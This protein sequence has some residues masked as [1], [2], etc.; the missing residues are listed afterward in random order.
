MSQ[1][2][3][4]VVSVCTRMG[5]VTLVLLCPLSFTSCNDQ[6]SKTTSKIT[7]LAF[8]DSGL[9]VGYVGEPY[10]ASLDVTGGITPYM[11][12]IATNKL[13]EGIKLTNGILEGTPKKEGVFTF[14]IEVAD[15][16]LNTR[17]KSYTLNINKL[18]KL[19]VVPLLPKSD[20]R[21]ESRIPIIIKSPRNVRAVRFI[22]ELNS[23][24][25]IKKVRLSDPENTLIWKISKPATK[26]AKDKKGEVSKQLFIADI[27]LRNIPKPNDRLLLVTLAPK[28]PINLKSQKSAYEARN[29]K[30]MLI[31]DKYLNGSSTASKTDG[32]STS[33]ST[34]KDKPS[35]DKN[36]KSK[37]DTNTST[38]TPNTSKSLTSPTQP[39]K[40]EKASPVIEKNTEPSITTDEPVPAPSY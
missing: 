2:Q 23:D 13:P 3:S 6:Q 17:V 21:G 22:W 12:R 27:G 39:S 20:L 19:S 35:T 33:S 4:S 28:S 37:E 11:Y 30:G 29:G 9:E 24:I 18:P 1:L 34:K 25:N 5:L 36:Q 31:S 26:K 7:T 8:R 15:A 16:N 32:K 40:N 14:I 38:T 10:R